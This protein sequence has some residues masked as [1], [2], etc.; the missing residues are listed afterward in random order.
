MPEPTEARLTIPDHVRLRAASLGE[1]GR[2]WLADLPQQVSDLERQWAIKVGHS[3]PEASEAFVAEAHTDVGQ[4]VI[5]KIV[6]AGFDAARQELRMLRAAHGKG[7]AKLIRADESENAFLLEK[8]GPSLHDL[9]LPRDK[10]IEIICH[11]LREAWM[12]TL[13][14]PPLVTGREKAE[15]LAHM[16]ESSWN[17]LGRPCS[18]Q[19]IDAALLYAKRRRDAFDPAK[20]VIVHGDAHEWNTLVAPQSTTGFKFVD[21]DGAFAERAYD[22]AISMRE[23]GTMIP[24]QDLL[25]FGRQRCD[26]LAKLTGV[27]RRAI[28]EWGLIQCVSNG[29]LPRQIGL[30]RAASVPLAMADA[31]T[32]DGDWRYE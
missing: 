9:N 3:Y 19:A 15:E 18:E 12:P 26:L 23:W 20:S 5:L 29:L 32:A 28:W 27:E 2:A 22:L 13:E 17:V 25:R 11:T 16:I 4:D 30:D 14:G 21:P 8:L 7:Y 6:M 1:A 24:D 31:W 10:Q